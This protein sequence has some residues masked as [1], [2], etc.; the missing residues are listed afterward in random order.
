M[1]EKVLITIS[2]EYG[3]YG[4]EIGRRLAKRLNIAYYDKEILE[5]AAEQLGVSKTF[6]S[7]DNLNESGLF[8]LSGRMNYGL[9]NLT[10]LS[11]S[12]NAYDTAR[13]IIRDLVA[14]ESMVLVGRCANV[15]LKDEP[16]IISVYCYGD[17]EDRVRRVIEEYGVPKA[18]ARKVVLDTDRKRAKFYE[19]Y[20]HRKWGDIDDFDVS[21]NTSKRTP[22]EAVNLLAEVF[23][24]KQKHLSKA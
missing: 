9:K 21:I 18:H 10:E 13:Q 15:I 22:E 8:S 20:T 12:T 5:N 14:K 17:L 6:F 1:N 23:C 11:L 24:E 19:Y 2:R 16:G 4:R 7:D 3:S